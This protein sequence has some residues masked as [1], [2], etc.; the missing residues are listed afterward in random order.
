MRRIWPVVWGLIVPLLLGP[1]V[2]QAQNSGNAARFRSL[3][4]DYKAHSVGDLVTIYIVEFSSASNS[5]SA[6]TKNSNQ[7]E[8]STSGSGVLKNFIPIFGFSGKYGNE[9][10]GDG[11]VTQRGQLKA[12]LSARIVGVGPNG[13]LKIQGKKV[14]DVNGDKQTTVLTGWVRP[15]D[16]TS[17]NV[18]YSYNIADAQISYKG[19]GVAASGSKPGWITRIINWIF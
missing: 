1:T 14:L 3:F 10:K 5:S 7:T 8:V 13:M 2:V 4:S 18:V 11:S 17:E 19:K 15:E 16:I 12:K 9:Y 6:N